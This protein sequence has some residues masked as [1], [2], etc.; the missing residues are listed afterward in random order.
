MIY[1]QFSI[2][3]PITIEY[4]GWFQ[5][6]GKVINIFIC[7]DNE[8]QMEIEPYGNLTFLEI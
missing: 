5:N 2:C 6:K 3:F 1:K 8:K 7:S 4:S